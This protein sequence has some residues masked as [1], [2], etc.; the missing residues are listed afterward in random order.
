MR[1]SLIILIPETQDNSDYKNVLFRR[2]VVPC[3][4]LREHVNESLTF[5][6][7][8]LHDVLQAHW[9]ITY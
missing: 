2:S 6:R 4:L 7:V 5:V 1:A 9:Y 3:A 8:E